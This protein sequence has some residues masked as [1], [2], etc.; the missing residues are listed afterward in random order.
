ML[1][2]YLSPTTP[3]PKKASE[4]QHKFSQTF[5]NDLLWPHFRLVHLD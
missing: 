5:T 1:F 2:T 4:K 3:I